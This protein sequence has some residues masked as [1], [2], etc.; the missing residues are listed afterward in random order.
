MYMYI[1]NKLCE[2][3]T[4]QM[5]DLKCKVQNQVI[6]EQGILHGDRGP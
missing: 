4:K 6:N 5:L 3:I 1:Y 2:N